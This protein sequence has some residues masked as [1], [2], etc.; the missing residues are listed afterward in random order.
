MLLSWSC[1]CCCP[2]MCCPHSPGR[3]RPPPHRRRQPRLRTQH[4]AAAVRQAS[5]SAVG[6]WLLDG[7]VFSKTTEGSALPFPTEM[8]NRGNRLLAVP[9]RLSHFFPCIVLCRPPIWGPPRKFPAR[10]PRC[11][12]HP[13]SSCS[14]TANRRPA[15]TS[16]LLVPHAMPD[17]NVRLRCVLTPLHCR[18]ATAPPAGIT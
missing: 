2:C 9:A 16:P 17:T 10:S 7:S 11:L 15:T 6:G 5:G 4:S 18:K 13:K 14:C 3:P 1:A 8:P 12:P